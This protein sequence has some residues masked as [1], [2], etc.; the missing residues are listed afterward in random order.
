MNEFDGQSNPEAAA[1]AGDVIELEPTRAELGPLPSVH[2]ALVAGTLPSVTSD[3]ENLLRNRL[4]AAVLFL[5]VAYGL[6][7]IIGLLDKNTTINRVVG[8][9]G[10]RTF[11]C[12]GLYIL[13]ASRV[14]LSFQRL[15]LL[16]YLFF[17][18]ITLLMMG[19][20]YVACSGLIREGN[21]P[22]LIVAEKNAVLSYVVVMVIYGVFIPNKPAMT[23]RVVLTMALGPLIVLTILET[24]AD[25]A[26]LIDHLANTEL[27]LANSLFILVGAALAIYTSYVLSGLRQ[28][29]KEAR[30]LGHYQLGDKLGEG[31]MGEVYLAEHRLLKR[32]CAL[33]LIKPDVNTNPLALARFE[34]EVQSAAMLSHPNTIE[35]FDYGHSDDGTFYY[36]MEY[37]PGMSLLDLVRH[38]GPLPCG[39]AVY[40]LCQ[41]CGALA[42]AHRLQLV[43]RDLKPANLFVAILGGKCDVAK[44]LDFG[45]VKLTAPEATQLTADYTVSGT[46]Q[47]MSPEQAIGA[48]EIDGRADIYALG[49][50]L[51][52][53]LT[54]RPPFEGATPTELMIAHARDPV[55]P[56]SQF[57]PG[58]PGDMEAVAL[59]CLS[60]KPDDRYQTA[61]DLSFA[62]AA[63]SC[64]SEW[65]EIKAEEWWAER[66]VSELESQSMADMPS[67]AVAA[68]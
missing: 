14:V 63:C 1:E 40:L 32:P 61:R 43:H 36:V 34:R 67:P 65:D 21:F 64:A 24:Q 10:I 38:Y 15:R 66:A 57:R 6:L 8:F 47:Y 11:L 9:F 27:T 44:V 59:K 31:G 68:V 3:S 23:A 13:L 30:Q 60:K 54:G 20:Q 5:A 7:F 16:E 12:V 25:K 28:E 4:K 35:I 52:F 33:K 53:M 46:P 26:S 22:H 29:L 50:I 42:E 19:S 51:Y 39:R 48:S 41:V 18:T 58:I 49:A 45:L 55:V 17:G 37:L 2:M 62:L 56:P